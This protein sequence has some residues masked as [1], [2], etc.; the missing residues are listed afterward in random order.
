MKGWLVIA[1]GRGGMENAKAV[2]PAK[3]REAL[4][5]RQELLEVSSQQAG[6]KA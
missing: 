1:D 6:R 3:V 4:V 5:G 2:W